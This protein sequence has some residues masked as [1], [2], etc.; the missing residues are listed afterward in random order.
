LTGEL[1][2]VAHPDRRLA[3]ARKFGLGL[4]L[5]PAGGEMPEGLAGH[6]SLVSALRAAFPS[7]KSGRE[8]GDAGVDERLEAA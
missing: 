2:Y 5:G 8:A 4:V 1:R 7:S 3:E 6:P